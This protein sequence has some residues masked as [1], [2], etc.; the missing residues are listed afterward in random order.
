LQGVHP[1]YDLLL[2]S[3]T[4]LVD[5]FQCI[6]VVKI[7]DG[8]DEVDGGLARRLSRDKTDEFRDGW[9]PSEARRGTRLFQADRHK[10]KAAQLGDFRSSAKQKGSRY[11]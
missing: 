11:G 5:I 1:R 2:R 9:I 8:I 6:A 7:L 3:F 4:S 10:Q